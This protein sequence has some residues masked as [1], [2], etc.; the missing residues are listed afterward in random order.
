MS[1][2]RTI[3]FHWKKRKKRIEHEY[4]IAGWALSVVDEIRKDVR[5]LLRGEHR[6]AIEIVIR[7]LHETPRANTHPD[8]VSMDI[9]DII[10]T[11]WNEFKSFQ[12]CDRPFNDA[13]KWASPDV[14][15]GR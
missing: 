13:G 1:F 3:L 5:A 4:A 2:G 10:D 6:T 11:F 12:N 15:H 8:I 7:R 14:T 9:S